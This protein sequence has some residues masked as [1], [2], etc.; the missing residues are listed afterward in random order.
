MNPM[1]KGSLMGA[2]ALGS[3]RV[4]KWAG[5][6]DALRVGMLALAAIAS[7][8]VSDPAHAQ[9]GGGQGDITTFLTNIVN[10]VTGTA[11]KSIA[12]LGICIAGIGAL[13]G[14]LSLRVV[15]GVILGIMML[16][17]ASWIVTQIVGQ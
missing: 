14:A 11:G 2:V 1:N 9:T 6:F 13:M 4:R 15:G 16:F 7:T 5:Q 10:L 8:V 3:E 12:V 17:S